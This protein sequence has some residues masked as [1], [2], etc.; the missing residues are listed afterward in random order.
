MKYLCINCN[1]IYDEALWD[2][3]EWIPAWTKIE[4]LERCPVCFEYDTFEW[5]KEE[6][7]YIEKNTN[8]RIELAHF[9]EVK[10]KNWILEVIIWKNSHPMWEEH[11]ICWVWL[12]D[13][14]S[15]LVDE[16][17]LSPDSD[18][19]V[20]FEDYNLWEFEV[21][22]KCSQHKLFGRKFVF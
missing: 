3:I 10:R 14:Y 17:F 8:D 1:Y 15:D 21:R 2:Y 19:I 5:I 12:F 9:I 7:I 22:I 16:E 13:E 6:V 4:R 11:R 18:S 20:E